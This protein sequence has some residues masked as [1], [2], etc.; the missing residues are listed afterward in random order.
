MTIT[1]K[2]M[3]A[4]VVSAALLGLPI[5][6]QA[7]QKA[8]DLGKREYD[9]NCAVCHGAKGKGDGPYPHPLGAAANLTRAAKCPQT[10]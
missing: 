9:A 7:Q 10:R 4:A 8:P 5:L 6:A 3:F 1:S 2:S